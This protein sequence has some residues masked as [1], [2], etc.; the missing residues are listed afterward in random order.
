MRYVLPLLIAVLFTCHDT[1]AQWQA[2][3]P[4]GGNIHCGLTTGGALLVGTKCGI[5]RSTDGGVSFASWSRSMPS[6]TIIS[7]AEKNGLLYACIFE[8]GVYTSADGGITWTLT[9]AGRYLR[10]DSFGSISFQEA[11]GQLFVRGYDADSLY[12]TND[13]INWT[14]RHIA[15]SLFNTVYGAGGNLFCYTPAGVLGAAAGLYR[16]TDLGVSWQLC[17]GITQLVDVVHGTGSAIHAFGTHAF[18]STDGGASFQQTTTTAGS[19]TPLYMGYDGTRYYFA[20]GGNFMVGHSTWLPGQTSFTSMPSVP[21]TGRT[22]TLYAHG[23]QVFLSG[24]VYFLSTANS[25]QSWQPASKQGINAI[26]L[27]DLHSDAQGLLAVSDSMFQH[28]NENDAQWTT[29]IAPVG[30]ELYRVTRNAQEILIGWDGFGGIMEMHHS[31]N[32]G[33]T[34]AQADNSDLYGLT[35]DWISIGDTLVAF[36][37]SAS[38]PDAD[39][40]LFD[41]QGTLITEFE[42]G[43]SGPGF[44]PIVTDLVLHDGDYY[45][46][47][48]NEIGPNTFMSK[49]DLPAGT[50]WTG[51]LSQIDGASFAG[52]A[53]LSHNGR[54]YMGMTGGGVKYS[55]DNGTSWSDL[56]TGLTDGSATDLHYADG[57]IYLASDRG[58]HY[59]SADGITWIDVSLDLP[60]E[61][62]SEITATDNYLWARLRDG[63]VWRLQLAGNVGTSEALTNGSGLIAYPNP[64][65][66]NVRID[67]P[68]GSAGLLQLVDATGRVVLSTRVAPGAASTFLDL[69]SLAPGAYTCVLRND[70]RVRAVCVVKQR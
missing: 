55:D 39:V 10:Q 3:G 49:L 20:Q 43:I 34:W 58:V 29:L 6:G 9:R 50:A 48:G 13:G 66:N 8:K 63:G 65:Q 17:T 64:A 40:S 4:F 57:V 11:G 19:F 5:Y 51:V 61:E 14:T 12:F 45:A 32:Q 41:P 38:F 23:G 67:V 35:A 54:L 18:T 53:L 36:G 47:V 1:C 7:L 56:N 30:G 60:V 22:I 31:S 70:A 28:M 26:A 21:T 16:S 2:I 52:G 46:L 25:G 27:K 42:G 37:E 69:S 24:D 15:A 62:V 33:T 59:L 44:D 68:E